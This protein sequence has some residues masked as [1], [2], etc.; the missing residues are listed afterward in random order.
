MADHHH[1]HRRRRRHD[2]RIPVLL[3]WLAVAAD[4]ECSRAHGAALR[5]LGAVAATMVPSGGVLW[6]PG[7]RC[8]AELRREVELVARRHLGYMEATAALERGLEDISAKTTFEER[9]VL[10]DCRLQVEAVSDAAY[11]YTGL[12]FGVTFVDGARR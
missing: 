9:D 7:E 4:H 8:D 2:G 5:D 6:M 11:Y 12:A 1:R 10:R 3:T